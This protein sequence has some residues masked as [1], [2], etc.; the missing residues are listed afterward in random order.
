MQ[1]YS[2]SPTDLAVLA[3]EL[4][5]LGE[6]ENDAAVAS[7]L[8]RMTPRLR[9]A[10]GSVS[11]SESFTIFLDDIHVVDASLQPE[12]LSFIYSLTRDNKPI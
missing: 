11:T 4:L 1:T 3:E 6:S 9:R 8:A 10:L 2:S 7:K 5:T 12:L